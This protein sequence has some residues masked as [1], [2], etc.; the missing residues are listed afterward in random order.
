VKGGVENK[1]RAGK[2]VKET[3]HRIVRKE[4]S[5]SSSSYL[6]VRGRGSNRPRRQ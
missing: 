6:L 5:S 1:R 3:G 2:Q 4:E